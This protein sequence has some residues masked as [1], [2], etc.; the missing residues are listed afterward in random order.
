MEGCEGCAAWAADRTSGIYVAS[1]DHCNARALARSPAAWRALNGQTDAEIRDAILR[2]FGETRYKHGRR[3][4]WDWIQRLKAA[5]AS[6]T[7]MNE[8]PKP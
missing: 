5:T 6:Q 8:G 4:V 3:L 1:C 7:E 2:V